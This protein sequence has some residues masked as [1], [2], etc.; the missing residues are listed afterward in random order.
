M[1]EVSWSMSVDDDVFYGYVFGAEGTASLQPLRIIKQFHGNLVNVAPAK[2][3]NRQA[4]YRKSYENE[5]RHFVG[6]VRR[7]HPVISTAEEAVQ[8]MKIVDAVYRSARLGTEISVSEPGK[9]RT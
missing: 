8:R 3:E 2:V 6:A 4:N 9:K 5:L 7:E 1:I